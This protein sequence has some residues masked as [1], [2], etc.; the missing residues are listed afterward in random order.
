MKAFRWKLTRK[1][2]DGTT[3]SVVYNSLVRREVDSKWVMSSPSVRRW[4][5]ELTPGSELVSCEPAGEFLRKSPVDK[6]HFTA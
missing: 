1:N 4:L 5:D 3:D 2:P 6:P